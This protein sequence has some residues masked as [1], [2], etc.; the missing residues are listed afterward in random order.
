[1]QEYGKRLTPL[2]EE[3]RGLFNLWGS[4]GTWWVDHIIS[5]CEYLNIDGIVQWLQVG[6]PT[7]L[8]LQKILSDR[9]EKELGILTLNLE[10]RMIDVDAYDRQRDE[11]KL[12][13]FIELCLDKK[14]IA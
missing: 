10:G 3:A 9:A 4:T 2:E 7:T 6:C 14:G 1:M 11:S 12:G 5:C 13:E 8:G